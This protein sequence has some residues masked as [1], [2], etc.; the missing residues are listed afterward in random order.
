[1]AGKCDKRAAQCRE[2]HEDAV[3]AAAA[4]TEIS[5]TIADATERC[6]ASFIRSSCRLHCVRLLFPTAPESPRSKQCGKTLFSLNAFY[7]L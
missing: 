2:E 5:D 4:E 6:L 7:S 1:M 3:Q